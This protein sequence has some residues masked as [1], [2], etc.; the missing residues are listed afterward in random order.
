MKM[1]ILALLTLL[2]NLSHADTIISKEGPSKTIPWDIEVASTSVDN[3]RILNRWAGVFEMGGFDSEKAASMKPKIEQAI[4]KLSVV[5][6]ATKALLK[7]EIVKYMQVLGGNKG[8]AA[9]KV[10]LRFDNANGSSILTNTFYVVRE[11]AGFDVTN[12]SILM[13]DTIVSKALQIIL[14]GSNKTTSLVASE[15]VYATYEEAATHLPNSVFGGGGLLF[16]AFNSIE[17]DWS[18]VK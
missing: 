1:I 14:D 17:P 2:S 10:L 15:N 3:D 6:N 18:W 7:V 8:V 13:I 16:G 11:E 5:E 4:T 12:I 9:A